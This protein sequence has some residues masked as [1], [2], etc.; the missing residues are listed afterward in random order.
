VL[1]VRLPVDIG[2]DIFERLGTRLGNEMVGG[3]GGNE[4]EGIGV[5]ERGGKWSER[6]GW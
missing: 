5:N 2:E 4:R 3:K 6:E 1:S